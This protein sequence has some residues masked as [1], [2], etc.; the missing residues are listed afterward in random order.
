MKRQFAYFFRVF[1]AWF[2]HAAA[3]SAAWADH[4]ADLTDCWQSAGAA[5]AAAAGVAVVAGLIAWSNGGTDADH[6]D[7]PQAE[8]GDQPVDD[9]CEWEE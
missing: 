9:F 5:A 2:I 1:C 8:E 6:M 3:P 4:C 7:I